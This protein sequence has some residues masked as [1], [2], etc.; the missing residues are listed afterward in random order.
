MANILNGFLNNVGQG[1]GNPKGTLG[2]FQ[3]AARLYNSQAM[4][5]APKGKWM[6][7]VV[8]NIN[9][10]AL[11]SAKFDIQKHG[12]AINMLVK[13]IDLP[14]FR[15]QVEKPIQYNRKRQ[16]H[17]KLEYDPISVGFH[18]D[19]FGLTT[20]LWAMYYG[21][22]FADSKH[23]G[24]AGSSAAGS[25]LSG[26]GNLIAGFIPG[27]NGLLG[28]VKGF[29]GS[30]DAGVPAAYQRN[31]YKGSALNTYRYGLDNGSGAPFFSSIQIFQLARH[32][33]QSYTLINPV[34]TSWSHDSLAT[35][36][37]EASGN[38]M[39]VAYEAVIYGAGAVSRGNPKGFATEFY[40]NQPSPLG[41]LGGG[42]TSLF[43]QGGVLGG[44]GDI[45]SD[46]GLG[47]NGFTLGTLIKGINVYNNAKK[48]TK[49]GLREEGFSI[50]KSALGASTGIDVSGVANVLF[51]KKA[52]SAANAPTKALAPV[53]A[54]SGKTNDQMIKTL[55]NN[56][57]AK[58][59]VARQA[60]ANGFVA[61]F[62]TG[63]AVTAGATAGIA[64]TPQQAAQAYDSLPAATK[65][66]AE[67]AVI[68][69]L[70]NN[71]PT[72]SN[73]ASAAIAKLPGFL[74]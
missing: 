36:S 21:Y 40:D 31:S 6:Y 30:S 5:L 58:A 62:A 55:N 54:S 7:H 38:T 50:F 41:L 60:F 53:A 48:L 70:E 32:Q 74:G 24:S 28:A 43:G 23:G 27:S 26:V 66:Q 45:L 19:N 57:A 14:K 25:L 71:D 61:G 72:V 4:R 65:A 18:D 29:L 46:L 3:H 35:S 12:T 15:A 10:R 33:Y 42:V 11:G 44:I 69:A 20:N 9:P 56:P 13:S 1:L 51:P 49:E 63:V 22:Y 47:G 67:A 68:K 16:I 8:F 2:D 64:I 73:I 34:I 17:T 52:S 37:T 59:A 39:Q